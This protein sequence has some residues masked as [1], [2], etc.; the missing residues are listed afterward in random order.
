[1]KN[2]WIIG[3]NSLLGFDLIK[4]FKK[5][6][7]KFIATTKE[8]VNITNID[9]I[10]WFVEKNQFTHIINCAAYTNV[11]EAEKE[12]SKCFL[13]NCIAPLYIGIIA[14]EYDIKVIHISTDYIFG[15]ALPNNNLFDGYT[16]EDIGSP[17][18]IYGVTKCKG[19]EVLLS[20]YDKV[21]IIRTSWLFGSNIKKIDFIKKVIKKITSEKILKIVD[22]QIGSPTYCKDLAENI[23]RIVD[24]K[25]IFHI[26]NKGMASWYDMAIKIL[27]AMKKSNKN[28]FCEKIIPIKST[29]IN[30]LAIRPTYSVLNLSKLNKTLN[31]EMRHWKEAVKE[32][33]YDFR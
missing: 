20:I 27:E 29:E 23:L 9:K 2:F 5:N 25:G 31:I 12:I 4:V 14:K 22:D 26:A 28:I 32:C 18:N 30:S 7:I 11:D 21:L 8:E 16:E 10:R 6:Q 24:K 17:C 33:V 1:M 13:I 19:E 15:A 3:K